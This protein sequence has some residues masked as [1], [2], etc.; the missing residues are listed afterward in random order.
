MDV[1]LLHKFWRKN[2]QFIDKDIQQ[3][4]LI[5]SSAKDYSSLLSTENSKIWSIISIVY[6]SI[7]STNYSVLFMRLFKQIL[8]A[9]MTVMPGDVFVTQKM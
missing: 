9:V 3:W 6:L 1:R 5:V 2:A 4:S 7:K 8:I